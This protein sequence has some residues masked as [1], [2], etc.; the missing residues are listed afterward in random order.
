MKSKKV[1][2]YMNLANG[3]REILSAYGRAG[4]D[5]NEAIVSEIERRW[6]ARPRNAKKV[7][8]GV[9]SITGGHR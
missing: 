6:K 4:I 5:P 7:L 9:G 3:G 1:P 2:V 8:R